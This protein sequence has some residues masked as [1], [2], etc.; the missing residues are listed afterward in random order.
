M[1]DESLARVLPPHRLFDHAIDLMDTFVLKV[2]KTYLPHLKEMDT[3]KE[4][5]DEHLKSGKIHKSQSLQ[6]S[7][8][9]S[10]QKK[11]GGL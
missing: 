2:S 5:I 7:L 6:A 11:D 8:F 4:F 9:F 1:F 10:V 3:C